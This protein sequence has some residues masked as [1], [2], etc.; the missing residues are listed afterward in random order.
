MLLEPLSSILTH[1][2][3]PLRPASLAGSLDA[4]KT[5]RENTSGWQDM[6]QHMELGGIMENT[7]KDNVIVSWVGAEDV[8]I[9]RAFCARNGIDGTREEDIRSC[10]VLDGEGANGPVR[11]LTDWLSARQIYLLAAADTARDAGLLRAF[12]ERGTKAACTVVE[13]G[14]TD[15]FSHEEVWQATEAFLARN[16]SADEA[17]SFSFHLTAGTPAMQAALFYASQ[18]RYAGGHA[19]RTVD[20]AHAAADGTQCHEVRLPFRLPAELWSAP[21]DVCLADAALSSEILKIYAPV[22]A[23]SILV[24]GETGVGKSFFARQ[25]HEACAGHRNNFAEVHCATLA[26]GPFADFAA[27]LFG[28]QSEEGPCPGAFEKARGGTLYLNGVEH[29]PAEWQAVLV[30]ALTEREYEIPGG[31]K[32]RVDDVRVVASTAR[33]LAQDASSGLFRQDLFTLIAMCPVRLP[34]LRDIAASDSARFAS[35]VREILAFLGREAKEF[36]RDWQIAPDA[37]DRLKACP[38]PGNV[39]QLRQVLLLSCVRALARQSQVITANDIERHLAMVCPQ[40]SAVY[41]PEPAAAPVPPVAPAAP[42]APMAPAASAAETEKSAAQVLE[43]EEEPGKV[44]VVAEPA[45]P[46]AASSA[47]EEADDFLPSNLEQWLADK[48][49]EFINKALAMCDGSKA[50]AGKLLGLTYQ[51]ML[52]FEKRAGQPVTGRRGRRRK[53]AEEMPAGDPALSMETADIAE[54][55]SVSDAQDKA[56][57]VVDEQI[58]GVAETVTEPLSDAVETKAEE[59]VTTEQSLFAS[60]VLDAQ[61]ESKAEAKVAEDAKD[62]QPEGEHRS[63]PSIDEI[64]NHIVAQMRKADNGKDE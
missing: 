57:P 53:N 35:I 4:V 47:S 32:R 17:A 26:A 51:Q 43:A 62:A 33:D 7:S 13:T 40:V 45:A 28:R 34:S 5:H 37:R 2:F 23:I 64:A 18:V 3:R 25:I 31:G 22:R 56:G 11:T 49:M 9:A 61:P 41:T 52:Y 29:L 21:L 63:E 14:V 19:W 44:E 39:Q 55:V 6:S 27:A 24:T 16:W 38:W 50:R 54:A 59:S 36:A 46:V 42:A 12:V 1:I 48:R 60:A 10:T 30:R 58:S 15:P 20:P 8:R